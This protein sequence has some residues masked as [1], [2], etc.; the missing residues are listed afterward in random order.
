VDI[1]WFRPA[2]SEVYLNRNAGARGGF[3]RLSTSQTREA[4]EDT[5]RDGIL[6]ASEDR[7][8]DG[9]GPL[10]PNGVLDLNDGPLPF[11]KFDTLIADATSADIPI[12]QN[13]FNGDGR[14]E[15]GFF[16]P[17]TG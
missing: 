5:N 12:G 14:D 6:A 13:D 9:S 1:G 3:A 7:D 17:S 4:S 2:T 10:L 15:I 16:R 8:P 11:P